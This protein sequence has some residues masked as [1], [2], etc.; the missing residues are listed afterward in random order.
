MRRL[1]LTAA[2]CALFALGAADASAFWVVRGWG[3]G[4]GA[5][6]SQYGAYGYARHGRGHRFILEHYYRDT[7][8]RATSGRTIEV[9]LDSG[10][11]T[12]RFTSARRACG[13]RIDAAREYRFERAGGEVI[14]RR[15]TGARIKSCG[16]TG[17]AGG[18]GSVRLIGE[19]RYRGRLK[20][21]TWPGGGLLV[22]NAVGLDPYA[23]GVI[24]LEMPSSWPA[25]ALR[26]QAVAARSYALATSGGGAFDVYDDTRSQVYGGVAAETGATDAAVR[27]S[28]GQIVRHGG[29]VATTYFFSTSGGRTENVEFAFPGAAP[30]PYLK[31]VRDPY[32]G[33]SPYHRWRLRL[34]QSEMESRLAGLFSGNLRRIRVTKTGESPR[35][36]RARVRGTA[37]GS[38]VSGQTLQSRL[39]L[40]STWARFA[41]R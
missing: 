34:S 7:R 10:V 20:A 24:A 19:G 4:H 22:V 8:V 18:G 26:A 3:N 36:V 29:E 6:M 39:G 5:G 41:K 25:A 33:L 21:K 2:A 28:D 9:L 40:S 35:I 15:R 37:G 12:V 16:A 13:R 14:L 31:S 38:E 30:K 23:R 1:T 32:D 17:E 11:G 27:D